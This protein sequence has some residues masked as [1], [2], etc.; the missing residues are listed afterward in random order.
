MSEWETNPFCR[1]FA[2]IDI[3]E[4]RM[5]DERAWLRCRVL[6]FLDT[7]YFDDVLTEKPQYAG[8]A[9]EL[10]AFE[11][12]Q[13]AGL[14][15]IEAQVPNGKQPE[16]GVIWNL[17]VHPDCQ[18]RGIGQRLLELAKQN[19]VQRGI[20]RFEAWTRNDPATCAWYE[21][22]GFQLNGCY[23]HVYLNPKE[24]EELLTCTD[25]ELKILKAFAQYTGDDQNRISG[26]FERTHEC[27]QYVLE[28]SSKG[29]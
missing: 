25:P 3:R 1:I 9:I 2:M 21:S 29:H 26:C 6:A 18:R 11:D 15:D 24:A 14:I 10:V 20:G 22:Q 12:N 17:A 19:A 16:T 28:F 5:A 7:P 23:L 8:S 4:Y 27:R 13:L